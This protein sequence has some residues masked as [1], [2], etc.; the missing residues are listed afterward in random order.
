VTPVTKQVRVKSNI[1]IAWAGSME[2]YWAGK[3]IGI[4]ERVM[5]VVPRS[6][7]LSDPEFVCERISWSNGTLSDSVDT[8]IFERVKQPNTVPVHSC[9]I[10]LQMILHC[11]FEGVAPASLNQRSW[12]LTIEDF[13]TV[14]T[15]DTISINVLVRDIEV[16]LLFLKSALHMY[17]R[18][19]WEETYLSKRANRCILIVISEY[20]VDTT[21]GVRVHDG[22]L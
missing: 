19:H 7:V 16:I 2:G 18:S 9:T 11:N 13:S 12:V 1:V 17:G 15:V 20:I 4:L 21:S 3:A 5:T 8:I 10:I 22:L 6:T 14:W